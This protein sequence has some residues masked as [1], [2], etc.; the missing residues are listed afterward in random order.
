MRQKT[1]FSMC[2]GV[3]C[4][5]RFARVTLNPDHDLQMEDAGHVFLVTYSHNC[6]NPSSSTRLKHKLSLTSSRHNRHKLPPLYART[7]GIAIDLPVSV[8]C[9]CSALVVAAI[10]Y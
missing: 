2:L 4:S 1:N 9:C 5:S 3:A 6:C 8:E 10:D 7:V